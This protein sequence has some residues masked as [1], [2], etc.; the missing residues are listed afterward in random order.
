[1]LSSRIGRLSH[2]FSIKLNN[3]GS[4]RNFTSPRKQAQYEDN[5]LLRLRSVSDPLLS[6]LPR[7]PDIVSQG[8]VSDID[9]DE[10][11]KNVQ[12]NLTLPT[13][14]HFGKKEL[15]RR[16]IDATL[17]ALPWVETT[18]VSFKIATPQYY[19]NTAQPGL[20]V[21]SGQVKSKDTIPPALKHV[22]SILAVA[23]CKGNVL[24]LNM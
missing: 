5:L 7:A 15:E 19:N 3:V 11:S 4:F 1:M 14:A 8:I 23:S 17:E 6:K 16:C 18:Q 12:I 2:G 20:R 22:G 10:N 13:G 9:I 21:S 24:K